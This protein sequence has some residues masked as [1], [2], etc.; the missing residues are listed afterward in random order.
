MP[1][2]ISRPRPGKEY[3]GIEY[4]GLSV[5]PRRI[6][7]STNCFRPDDVWCFTQRSELE[8]DTQGRINAAQVVEA[9]EPDATA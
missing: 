3:G 8:N 7:F 5:N 6:T 9:E 4:G 2:A 1:V